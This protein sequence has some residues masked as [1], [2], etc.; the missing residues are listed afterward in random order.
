MM[1][2][3]VD[4]TANPWLQFVTDQNNF[5]RPKYQLQILFKE[6]V[7]I[8]NKN[9]VISSQRSADSTVRVQDL[10]KKFLSVEFLI[11]LIF[12]GPIQAC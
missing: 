1:S 9:G 8:R 12:V 7:L 5:R 4:V 2:F 6:L 3:H 10:E 11:F